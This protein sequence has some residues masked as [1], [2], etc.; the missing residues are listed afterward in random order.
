MKKTITIRQ[1]PDG[2]LVPVDENGQ[3]AHKVQVR[4]GDVV[5]WESPSPPVRINFPRG[6]PFGPPGS[7]IAQPGE[8]SAFVDHQVTAERGEV[9]EYECGVTIQGR[10]EGWPGPSAPGSGGEIEIVR[11]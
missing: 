10:M 1:E 2:R 9:F 8:V 11:P 6:S 7:P 5:R 3:P 4:P